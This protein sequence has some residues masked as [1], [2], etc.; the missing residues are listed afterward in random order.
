MAVTRSTPAARARRRIKVE[1]TARGLL[2][3]VCASVTASAGLFLTYKAATSGFA[4]TA[5]RIEKKEILNLNSL[6]TPEEILPLLGYI[7]SDADK[8]FAATRLYDYLSGKD[9]E[10]GVPRV[11][12]GV[13]ALALLRVDPREIQADARLQYYRQR[14]EERERGSTVLGERPLQL[15]TPSDISQLK[16]ALVVREPAEFQRLFLIYAGA[17]V[18]A[19]FIVFI[20]M[21]LAGVRVDSYILPILHA[22]TGLGLAAMVSLRDPLRDSTIFVDFAQGVIAGAAVFALAGLVDYERGTLKKL[23]FIPLIAAFA[24]SAS[25]MIFGEGPAGSDA[26]VNLLGFQPVEVIKILVVLFLAGYFASNWEFLRELKQKPQGILSRMRWLNLPRLGY[27][28][29]VVVGMGLVLIFFRFQRDLGP[30]LILSCTFLGLY[31]V[32]RRRAVMVAVALTGLVGVFYIAYQMRSPAKVAE[33]IEMWL[34]PWQNTLRGGDQLAHSLWAIS[35]GSL[36]GT[37]LGLGD[38]GFIPAGHTDLIGSTIGEELG[39]IGLLAVLGLFALLIYRSIVIALDAAGDYSMFLGLGLAM[40]VAV[41]IILIGGG[42]VGLL[43]LSGVVLPFLSYGKSSMIAN[44]AVFGI[45]ASI[46]A[47]G[48]ALGLSEPFKKPVKWVGVALLIP[49]VAI[50]AKAAHAQVLSADRFVASG[51]LAQQADRTLRYIYN[52][53]L[54]EVA[55]LIPRGQI[56]DRNGV[57]LATSRWEDIEAK[58]ALF[59]DQFGINIDTGISRPDSRYYPFG[60]RLFYILGD[61][62]TRE[63]WGSPIT[64]FVER[65]YSLAL[66]GYGDEAKSEEVIDR[67]TGQARSVMKRDYSELVPLLRHRYEPDHEAVKAILNRSRDVRL[68]IDMRLQIEAEKAVEQQVRAAGRKKGAAVVIDP[69]TGDLLASVSYPWPGSTLNPEEAREDEAAE[70]TDPAFIDRARWGSYSPGSTFKLVTALAALRERPAIW[71]DTTFE[72]T[73]VSDPRRG[74][75]PRA[76]QIIDNQKIFDDESD[77]PFGHGDI[78]MDRAIIVSCN[79]YFAQLGR[80]I[81]AKAL[82]ETS[83]ILGL[84]FT[85]NQTAPDLQSQLLQSAFGQGIVH[86]TPFQMARVSATIANGGFMPYGRWVID[87]NNMRDKE[88]ERLLATDLASSL[89][90]AMMRVIT[91]GTGRSFAGL[92]A[93]Q[94]LLAHGVRVGGKTGTAETDAGASHSW[95]TGFASYGGG[96]KKIAF[97]VFIK[98]GG[99]GSVRALP[100]AARIIKAWHQIDARP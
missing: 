28:L 44:F 67:E 47:R 3:L 84:E 49:L 32:A 10:D 71:N 54:I 85:K 61:A 75:L 39:F 76:G 36:T 53:R 6:K 69:A 78:A 100:A 90:E 60:K 79:A 22:L 26:K 74:G 94:Y 18:A 9:R 88:P 58:R 43:P 77:S 57:P 20:G 95:F 82:F 50:M 63:N 66:Q 45:L 59:R 21:R 42:T 70:K 34:S 12:P 2:L 29:P 40:I 83:E 96:R 91:E 7:T 4:E 25:L 86:A 51:A 13:G 46:S 14:L 35:T 27:V 23:S 73:A 16:P 62:R 37:G 89:S 31:A 48:G 41:E 11:M 68:S 24:L 81:K 87:K 30:A 80:S 72:C 33:R 17:F 55:K 19:F 8:R 97:C 52:P 65:D 99:Y 98:H 56:L 15:F 5:T 38:P 93:G 64:S 92:E 1:S